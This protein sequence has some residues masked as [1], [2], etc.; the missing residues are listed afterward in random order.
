MVQAEKVGQR[1]HRKLQEEEYSSRAKQ[2]VD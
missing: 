2:R 1:N